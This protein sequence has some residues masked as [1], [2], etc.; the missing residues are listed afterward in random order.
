MTREIVNWEIN[1]FTKLLSSYIY[2]DC[3]L[4][5]EDHPDKIYLCILYSY[6]T[7]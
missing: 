5:L 6:H 4:G 1:C 2:L 3:K 7:Y